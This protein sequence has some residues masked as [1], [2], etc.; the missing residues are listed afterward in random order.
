MEYRL[1][2]EYSQLD[3]A[4]KLEPVQRGVLE[5]GISPIASIRMGT[6]VSEIN[7]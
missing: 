7:K 2:R 1:K 3:N 6:D 4:G 5:T